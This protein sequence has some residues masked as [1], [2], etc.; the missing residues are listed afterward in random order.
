MII[1]STASLVEKGKAVMAYRRR[2]SRRRM[3]MRRRRASARRRP[4]RQRIGYRM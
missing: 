4:L 1:S 3:S 2:P